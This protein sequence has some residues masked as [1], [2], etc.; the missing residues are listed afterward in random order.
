MSNIRDQISERDGYR[1]VLVNIPTA[2]IDIPLPPQ[3]S[4]ESSLTSALCEAM[5]ILP[6]SKG[7]AVCL[8]LLASPLLISP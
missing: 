7:D 5:H 1:C 8:A 2:P 6:H 4:S 3:A